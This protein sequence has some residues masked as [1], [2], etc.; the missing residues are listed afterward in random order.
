MQNS[1]QQ[2]RKLKQ[3]VKIMWADWMCQ[4]LFLFLLF[5]CL[6]AGGWQREGE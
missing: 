3:L 5:Q 4:V 6:G 2:L 1:I